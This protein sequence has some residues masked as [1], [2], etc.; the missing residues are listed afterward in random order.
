[1]RNIA[2]SSL[3]TSSQTKLI[4][5]ASISLLHIRLKSSQE[6]LSRTIV[7]FINA[8]AISPLARNS[9]FYAILVYLRLAAKSRTYKQQYRIQLV[10]S[11]FSPSA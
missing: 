6:A 3:E 10:S 11:Q 2:T 5:I 1:M 9:P 7:T 8:N 4:S